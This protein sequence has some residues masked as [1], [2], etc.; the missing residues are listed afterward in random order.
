MGLAE[1]GAEAA[2]HDAGTEPSSRCVHAILSA[3]PHGG[4]AVTYR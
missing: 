3:N 2:A 4:D 1:A